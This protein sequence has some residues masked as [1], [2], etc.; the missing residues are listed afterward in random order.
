MLQGK[1]LFDAESPVT[2][3]KVEKV[4]SPGTCKEE[5]RLSIVAIW[6]GDWEMKGSEVDA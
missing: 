4:E 1:A 5:A 6:D 3:G 2:S